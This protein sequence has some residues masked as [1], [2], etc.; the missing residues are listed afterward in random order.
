MQ[1]TNIP[2]DP[3]A[4]EHITKELCYAKNDSG[5]YQ[6]YASTGWDIKSTALNVAWDDIKESIATAQELVNQG[7]RSPIYAF[8]HT[9]MMTIG[10]LAN[11]VGMCRIRVWL[12]TYPFWFKHMRTCT[13]EKY[14]QVFNIPVSNLH[15][16][17]KA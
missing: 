1:H 9:H 12:H 8:M 6:T 5:N 2:Q 13:I 4:L 7:K 11:Y 3:S 15:Y 14:A 10:I 17:A 16:T